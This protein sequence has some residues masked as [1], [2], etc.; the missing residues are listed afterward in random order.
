MAS[1]NCNSCGEQTSNAK[2]CNT[3]VEKYNLSNEG[4]KKSE[5]VQ[6]L[7]KIVNNNKQYNATYGLISLVKVCFFILV[8]FAIIILFFVGSNVGFGILLPII[9]LV[10]LIGLIMYVQLQLL[11]IFADVAINTQNT[12]RLIEKLLDK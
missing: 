1:N 5:P 12:S 2:Y 8:G 3:C 10:A 11:E 4:I 7:N 6:A 9:L